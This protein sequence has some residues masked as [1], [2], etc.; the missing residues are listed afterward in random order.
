MFLFW[1]LLV[2][3]LTLSAYLFCG[4]TEIQYFCIKGRWWQNGIGANPLSLPGVY[5]IRWNNFI[6]TKDLPEHQSIWKQS[7]LHNES[8]F[9]QD[10]KEKERPS[11]ALQG[12]VTQAIA[13]WYLRAYLLRARYCTGDLFELFLQE[14]ALLDGAQGGQEVKERMGDSPCSLG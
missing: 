9:T 11:S 7:W 8:H 1:G 3:I 2:S 14:H 13:L 10:R 4:S 12:A 5:H 6:F